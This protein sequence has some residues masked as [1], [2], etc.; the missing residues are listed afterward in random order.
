MEKI[1]YLGPEGTFTEVAATAFSKSA[2]RFPYR[3]IPSCLQAL[4]NDEVDGAVVPLENTI[5]GSVNITLDHLVHKHNLPIVGELAIPIAQHLL[6]HPNNGGR[7]M[8]A[9]YSHPH[10]LAQCHD[11]LS[12]HLAAAEWMHASSTAKAA[13]EIAEDPS[14]ERAVIANRLAAKKYGLTIAAENIHDFVNNHTR[15]VFLSRRNTGNTS[16]EN[17]PNANKKTT[18]V[19]TLPSDYS[20]ALHQVLSAFAWRKLNLSKIESRPMKTGIGHYFFII[21]IDHEYDDVLVPGA[22]EEIKAIG[23][24]TR[25]LGSYPSAVI[26]E[27]TESTV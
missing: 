25:L 21:D 12:N 26:H 20:G 6:V 7:S 4:A 1:A 27:E 3:D 11:Y 24:G 8:K 17:R 16:M 15:F 18:I 14:L 13:Q 10:A 9:V 23:C 22:L 2:E 5:E 19:V